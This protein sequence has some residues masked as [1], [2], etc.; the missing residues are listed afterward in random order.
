M[1]LEKQ[2]IDVPLG[3]GTSDQA[4][5]YL[6]NPPFVRDAADVVATKAG[7][8]SKHPGADTVTLSGGP[9]P[10]GCYGAGVLGEELFA[11]NHTGVSSASEIQAAWVSSNAE[12][13]PP[14]AAQS[15]PLYHGDYSIP[16]AADVARCGQYLAYVW[17]ENSTV[18]IRV[19]EVSSRVVVVQNAVVPN[20]GGSPK[21]CGANGTHFLVFGKGNGGPYPTTD[22]HVLSVPISTLSLAGATTLVL[23][24]VTLYDAWCSED[25]SFSTAYVGA[26]RTASGAAWI[27]SVSATASVSG[28]LTTVDATLAIAV[29]VSQPLSRVFLY[30]YNTPAGITGAYASTALGGLTALGVLFV[31]TYNAANQPARMTL[32]ERLSSGEPFLAITTFNTA[33][34]PGAMGNCVMQWARLTS[35]GGLVGGYPKTEPHLLVASRGFRPA[36]RS[37][38][39]LWAQAC[40]STFR[41]ITGTTQPSAVR[42]YGQDCLLL[43]RDTGDHLSPVARVCNGLA[44]HFDFVPGALT[45]APASTATLDPDFVCRVVQ[46]G[47]T[48]EY[49]SVSRV[50]A[51]VAGGEVPSP[52]GGPVAGRAW[53]YGLRRLSVTTPL[54]VP[55][56]IAPGPLGLT[57][58][59]Q[60]SSFDGFVHAE[61]TPHGAPEILDVPTLNLGGGFTDNV[62][63]AVVLTWLD[64]KGF[65]HRSA[66][67]FTWKIGAAFAWSSAEIDFRVPPS[68]LPSSREMRY[69]FYTNNFTTTPNGLLRMHATGPLSGLANPYPGVRRI[70]FTYAANDAAPAIY[71][72]GGEIEARMISATR[73]LALHANRVW[74]VDADDPA[75]IVPSKLSATGLSPEWNPIMG[76]RT[77]DAGHGPV[78]AMASLDDKLVGFKEDSLFYVY[79]DGPNNLG[80]GSFSGP[81]RIESGG[82]GC[83]NRRSVVRIPDGIIFQ[84]QRGFY[85]LDRGLSLS[86]IGGP[87][88]MLDDGALAAPLL[89][90]A[91]LAVGKRGEARFYCASQAALAMGYAGAQNASDQVLI[92][93]YIS[94]QW[95]RLNQSNARAAVVWQDQPTTVDRDFLISKESDTSWVYSDGTI[96]PIVTT[97][98]IKPIG[99]TQGYQRVW[100]AEFLLRYFTGD[101]RIEV[102]HDY[103]EAFTT[104]HQWTQAQLLALGS[105][106][107]TDGYRVRLAVFPKRQKCEALRFR[108]S[109]IVIDPNTPPDEGQGF[110][111]QG[112]TLDIGTKL[113]AY[114]MLPDAAKK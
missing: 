86:Y 19:E 87:V 58:G 27:Y 9:S 93:N 60:I 91:A 66:P 110:E 104:T 52:A 6:A 75:M 34:M 59:G 62:T 31:P 5:R 8:L 71:T 105:G 48:D 112:L 69:E 25:G 38:G 4:A 78:V 81:H 79:G 42:H 99:L 65:L 39:Y 3:G 20:L 46:S 11:V 32:G 107:A 74:A 55:V 82:V 96:R 10:S 113:G 94:G 97:A 12:G 29:H 17:E 23:D 16:E 15:D 109:E 73:D 70:A 111:I 14:V 95:T 67:S 37:V 7:T 64:D 28:I 30:G 114:K 45:G 88:E 57:G 56:L 41:D 2:T 101:L 51:A 50:V 49:L 76:I 72:A 43:V 22:L 44:G 18:R 106:N 92:F 63:F 35:T 84:G 61:V 100:R 90:V 80:A 53:K 40:L 47:L 102:G 83:V 21:V 85:L 26:H 103:E 33:L 89:V 13:A 54:H 77:H 1:A 24:G 68:A 98:W 36:N 108:V